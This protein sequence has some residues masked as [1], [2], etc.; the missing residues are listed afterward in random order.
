LLLLLGIIALAGRGN[1]CDFLALLP[2]VVALG[3]A[4]LSP[5]FCWA[6]LQVLLEIHAAQ[7]Q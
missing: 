6:V 1:A 4:G 2:S 7:S 3:V 5:F